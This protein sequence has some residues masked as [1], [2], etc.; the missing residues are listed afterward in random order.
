MIENIVSVTIWPLFLGAFIILTNTYAAIGALASVSTVAALVTA[1]V[2]G[3]LIDDNKGR[4]LLNIGA[5]ANACIHICRIFVTTISQAF[6]INLVNEPLTTMYRMPM[7]KG[8]YDASDS[9]PGYRIIY[10]MYTDII[11]A[12]GNILFWIFII[13]ASSR[14]DDKVTL[15]LV[16]IIGAI[17]SIVITRQKFAALRS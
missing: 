16:F 5:F 10:Y 4:L 14:L 11:C 8:I 13:I 3:K 2:I 7:L 1:F 12:V 6:A 15:Q 17:M 9:V